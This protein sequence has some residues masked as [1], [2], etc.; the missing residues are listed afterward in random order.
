MSYALRTFAVRISY[1]ICTHVVRMCPH[2]LCPSCPNANVRQLC[3][4]TRT[5][6]VRQNVR[7]NH[8]YDKIAKR[9][10]ILVCM[11]YAD[12]RSAYDHRTDRAKNVVRYSYEVCTHSLRKMTVYWAHKNHTKCHQH[13]NVRTI[14]VRHTY[15]YTACRTG[16]LRMSYVT[17]LLP[18]AQEEHVHQ[19]LQ[20]LRP[21]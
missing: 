4:R 11:S 18:W 14:C 5:K 17:L 7:Q 8:A 9:T 15:D 6:C 12:T 2:D 10:T 21:R 20:V 3:V 1:V 13:K 16:S 19:S